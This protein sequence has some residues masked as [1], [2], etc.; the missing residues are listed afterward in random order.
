MAGLVRK[1]VRVRSKKGKTYMR[2]TMVRS[3]DRSLTKK[4]KRTLDAFSAGVGASSGLGLALHQ[5]GYHAAGLATILSGTAL[6]FAAMRLSKRGRELT[7]AF[8]KA[9]KSERASALRRQLIGTTAALASSAAVGHRV[10]KQRV[11]DDS[12]FPPGYHKHVRPMASYQNG[13][14]NIDLLY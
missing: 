14:V 10:V 3:E 12:G 2:S 11:V 4:H 9:S 7:H 6:S 5:R 1:K 13:K 8:S